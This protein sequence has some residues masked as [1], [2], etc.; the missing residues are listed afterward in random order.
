MQSAHRQLHVLLVNDDLCL[1]FRGGNH[2]DVDALFAQYTEHATG[3]TYVAAHT[4]TND[5][6]FADFGVAHYLFGPQRGYH[7]VLQ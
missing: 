1:D 3:H 2:L 6:Y 7:L 4:D 5:G